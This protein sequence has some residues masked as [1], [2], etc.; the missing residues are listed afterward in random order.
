MLESGPPACWAVFNFLKIFIHFMC[1]CFIL[2]VYM[3]P[4]SILVPAEVSREHWNPWT[5][6]YRW[7]CMPGIK[8]GSFARAT[9]A[10]IHWVIR[11]AHSNRFYV[12][13]AGSIGGQTVYILLSIFMCGICMSLCVCVTAECLCLLFSTFL[14]ERRSRTRPGTHWLG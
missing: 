2:H 3:Y 9:R 10:L 5:W 7:L 8:P 13:C 1:D 12:Q 4:I 11:P 6:F 14:S